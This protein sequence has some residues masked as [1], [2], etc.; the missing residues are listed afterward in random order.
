M[1]IDK[2]IS[3][4]LHLAECVII[5]GFGGLITNY[6]PSQLNPVQHSFAPPSK[7]VVFNSSLKNNDGLLAN[8][9]ADVDN[10]SYLHAINRINHF[11]NQLIGRLK[12]GQIIELENIGSFKLD[13]EGQIIFEPNKEVNFYEES[14][15]LPTFISPVVRRTG[16]EKTIERKL[17]GYE[18]QTQERNRKRIRWAAAIALP[19]AAAVLWATYADIEIKNLYQQNSNV[20]P[21]IFHTQK[22]IDNKK[23]TVKTFNLNRELI[24]QKPTEPASTKPASASLNETK[25]SQDANTDNS[26]KINNTSSAKQYHIIVASFARKELAEQ[27]AD[28]LFSEGHDVKVIGN[29]AANR[30]RVSIMAISDKEKALIKLMTIRNNIRPDAW[31][32]KQ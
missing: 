32:L 27:K 24:I 16:R 4:L 30:F 19:F 20:I 26:P 8:Y 18:H 2:H 10:I 1:T 7:N 15:G 13:S 9:I 5:P 28:R 23:S 6:R 3:E 12:S 14:Y 17:L 22:S 11:V 25:Q 31:L 29:T 21:D